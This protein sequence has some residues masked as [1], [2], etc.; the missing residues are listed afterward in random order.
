MLVRSHERSQTRGQEK[1]LA[2]RL[3]GMVKCQESCPAPCAVLGVKGSVGL[4][5]LLYLTFIVGKSTRKLKRVLRF[6][7]GPFHDVA[8]I[9]PDGPC[10]ADVSL[11]VPGGRR[12]RRIWSLLNGM[13]VRC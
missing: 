10:A 1:L 13:Y 3:R 4:A 2:L 7:N 8:Q 5:N 9:K 11:L 12:G 6:R